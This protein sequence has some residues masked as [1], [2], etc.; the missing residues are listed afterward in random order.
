LFPAQGVT[1][2]TP[3]GARTVA[4]EGSLRM[5]TGGPAS[6]GRAS[7][8]AV[9]QVELWHPGRGRRGEQHRSAGDGEAGH[10]EADEQHGHPAPGLVR[11]SAV[12]GRR[13]VGPRRRPRRELERFLR[14]RVDRRP[15]RRRGLGLPCALRACRPVS[16]L[17]PQGTPARRSRTEPCHRWPT[18][19]RGQGRVLS[20]SSRSSS[21]L[22]MPV[23][24]MSPKVKVMA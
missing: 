3:V 22:K 11:I 13:G 4:P 6:S 23:R 15:R 1:P 21:Q 18:P 19:D 14:L 2:S 8:S 10:D 24:C 17:V 9:R 7:R 12:G 5:T 16:A 20:D